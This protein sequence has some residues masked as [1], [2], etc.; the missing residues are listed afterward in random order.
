MEEYASKQLAFKRA[1]AAV[2]NIIDM[3]ETAIDSGEFLDLSD[4][5]YEAFDEMENLADELLE[6]LAKYHEH[7]GMNIVFTPEEEDEQYRA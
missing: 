1:A 6:M 2:D 7:A 3:M 4:T 5:E